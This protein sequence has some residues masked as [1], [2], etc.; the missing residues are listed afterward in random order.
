MTNL[1]RKAAVFTDLHLG[2]KGNS[3]QFLSDCE[4]YI[5]WFI[6]LVRA[7]DC[8]MILFLGDF[9]HHR[10]SININT[11]NVS[12]RSL[13][14]L[15]ALGLPVMFIPGN[16]DLYHKDKRTLSSVKYIEKFKNFNLIMD[17][18]TIDGVAFVPW[19]M[20]EEHRNMQKLKAQYVMGHFEL[21]TFLMNAMV[22]MPDHGSEVRAND[23][24]SVG[25]VFTGH[26]HKRQSK[27]NISYIGNAFPHNYADAWDD[28]RGA[29]ILEWGK[30]PVYHDWREGP[31][32]RTLGLARLIDEAD[33]ILD[34]RTYVRVTLDLPIS[35]EEATFIKETM[36]GTYGCRDL[37][38][39]PVKQQ[40]D[41]HGTVIDSTFESVDTIVLNQIQS[42]DSEHYDKR[43]LMDIY[44][45]L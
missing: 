24:A 36:L 42:I 23:F 16:H 27:G 21:P 6:D 32:Y 12:L 39:I 17:T 20:T 41:M 44:N 40:L 11:M 18:V 30:T 4:R 38:L 15:D 9:H 45:N 37:T 19:L 8:D 14:R 3:Q 25:H 1:F 29:M 5:T 43:L 33:K 34:E 7:E 10:N 35:Y 22:E 28:A 31:K 13:E 26:F 2:E